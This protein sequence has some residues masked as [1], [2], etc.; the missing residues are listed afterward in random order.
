MGIFVGYFLCS[1]CYLAIII[2]ILSHAFYL[3]RYNYRKSSTNSA[4][5]VLPHANQSIS[6]D[7]T[8]VSSNG[9]TLSAPWSQPRSDV[10]AD[11]QQQ[12]FRFGASFPQSIP[13]STASMPVI[14]SQSACGA[15]RMS[16][17]PEQSQSST[18][19]K[20]KAKAHKKPTKSVLATAILSLFS[21][22]PRP[23]VSYL[24]SSVTTTFQSTSTSSTPIPTGPTHRQSTIP[25]ET[26]FYKTSAHLVAVLVVY[27][28]TWLGTATAAMIAFTTGKMPPEIL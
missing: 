14:P 18:N 6:T 20:L 21:S 11:D 24:I 7:A 16:S 9:S 26:I 1:L 19:A 3:R 5:N 17:S 23:T 25:T 10:E 8:I 28:L 27:I 13:Q 4:N 12:P 22:P 2:K 15:P